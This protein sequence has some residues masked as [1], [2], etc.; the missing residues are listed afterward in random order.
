VP[1]GSQA[2]IGTANVGASDVAQRGRLRDQ[3]RD[4]ISALE[5]RSALGQTDLVRRGLFWGAA[6]G[7]LNAALAILAGRWLDRQSEFG[8]YAYSPMP[9]R[10]ADY[11]P[12]SGSRGWSAF[13]VVIVGFMAINAVAVGLFVLLRARRNRAE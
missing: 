10:Y 9:R 13:V 7:L 2:G 12:A 6:L 5:S 8:W 1:A 4:R 11:L 3:T